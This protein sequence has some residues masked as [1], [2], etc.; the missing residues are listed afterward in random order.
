M[1]HPK[2]DVGMYVAAKPPLGTVDALVAAAQE[3]RLDSVF[4]WDHFQDFFPSAIWDEEFAWFA[5]PG[6]SPT[7]RSS[8]RRCSATWPPR[9]RACGWGSG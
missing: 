3:Q 5:A 6:S 8:S 4:V 2:I 7:S 9:P 1:S